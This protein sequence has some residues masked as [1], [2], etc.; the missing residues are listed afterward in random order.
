MLNTPGGSPTASHISAKMNKWLGVWLAAFTTHGATGRNGRSHF[1]YHLPDRIIP[2]VNH[3]ANSY[4]LI[5]DNGVANFPG[6]FHVP[7]LLGKRFANDG[8]RIYLERS[9]VL[10]WHA[11]LIENGLGQISISSLALL[12]QSFAK[13]RLVQRQKSGT[14]NQTHFWLPILRH[15]HLR[16]CHRA[17]WLKFRPVAGLITSLLPFPMGSTHWPLI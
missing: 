10:N 2:G 14:R 5:N 4:R 12:L 16:H 9:R 1:S 8:Q 13:S 3:G 11:Q 6:L 17:L 15:Q 7:G